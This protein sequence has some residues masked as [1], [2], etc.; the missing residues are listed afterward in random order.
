MTA[1][2]LRKRLAEFCINGDLKK[3]KAMYAMVEEDIIAKAKW[4]EAFMNELDK[5]EQSYLDG[6][7]KMYTLEQAKEAA[8][9]RVN[10]AK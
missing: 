2:T 3:V 5:R 10:S 7:A 1:S 9:E 6:T 4:D 8:R